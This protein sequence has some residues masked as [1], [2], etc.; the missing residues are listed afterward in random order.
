MV[1]WLSFERCTFYNNDTNTLTQ[2]VKPL[3]LQT[4]TKIS[5][6][7]TVPHDDQLDHYAKV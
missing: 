2:T 1:N 3:P 6:T 7:I 5:L 4:L